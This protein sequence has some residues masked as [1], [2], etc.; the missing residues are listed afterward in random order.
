MSRFS[1]LEAHKGW[2]IN[3]KLQKTACIVYGSI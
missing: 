1:L 3:Y 2:L